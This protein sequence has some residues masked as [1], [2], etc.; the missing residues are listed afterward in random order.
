MPGWLYMPRIGATTIWEDWNGP[1]SN[2]GMGGGIASLNHYSKGA[3][4]EWIFSELCGVKVYGENHFVIAP[5]P[6]G[7]FTHASF[8]YDSIYGTVSCAWHI[9]EDG[10]YKFDIVVPPNTTADIILPDE[11]EIVR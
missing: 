11:A 4:C 1:T 7:H 2:T 10:K 8:S 6:G 9:Q 5:H 3:V